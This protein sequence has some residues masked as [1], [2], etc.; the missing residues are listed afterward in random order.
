MH[1]GSSFQEALSE[2]KVVV[3]ANT[4][5][6]QQCPAVTNNSGC[7]PSVMVHGGQYL[8]RFALTGLVTEPAK[9]LLA[10]FFPLAKLRHFDSLN[11]TTFTQPHQYQ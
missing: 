8:C 3:T 6:K 2:Q 7:Q 5:P 11:P 1:I 4:G 9:L 10:H